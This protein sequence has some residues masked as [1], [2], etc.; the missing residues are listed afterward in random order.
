MFRSMKRGEYSLSR[1]AAVACLRKETWGVLSVHGDGGFP[2]GVPMNYVWDGG[3]LLLHCSSENS[4][5]LDSLHRDSKVCFTVVPE[6]ELDRE[7]W[8]T[9]YTSIILFGTAEILTKPE[10][11]ASAIETFLK[12]L[13]PEK[14]EEAVL[15]CDPKMP[16]LIMIRIHP[17]H[18][19][20]KQGR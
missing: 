2:Y 17:V 7:H 3:T 5:R 6:H 4:H 18:I 9:A 13:A 16:G 14:T 19:T 20:G 1:E 11:K 15:A 12:A 10:E 8:T